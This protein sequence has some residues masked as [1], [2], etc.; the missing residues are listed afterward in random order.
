MFQETPH[1]YNSCDNARAH[2]PHPGVMNVA[3]AD[4]SVAS[5]GSSMSETIWALACNPQDGRILPEGWE[6]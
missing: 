6:Q 4:G 3:M 2:T 5:V 1:P